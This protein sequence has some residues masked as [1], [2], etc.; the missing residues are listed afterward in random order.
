MGKANIGIDLTNPD[1]WFL[2]A[3]RASAEI[4]REGPDHAFFL[5][6]RLVNP[7]GSLQERELDADKPGRGFSSA[8]GGTIHHALDRRS[9]QHEEVARKFTKLIIRKLE[10]VVI[11][12]N[13]TNIVLI[14]EPHFLGLMRDAL[15]PKL[16][17]LVKTTINKEFGLRSTREM[18]QLI[19]SEIK[20]KRP[21]PPES[22]L[23][24]LR[25]P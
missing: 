15:S 4:Y 6:T 3:N 14:A 5:V 18:H 12:N 2:V 9:H 7:D 10:E 1:Q 25:Q 19:Q 20:L 11:E 22:F 24:D 16:K 23:D 8:G 17:K 13:A 21:V